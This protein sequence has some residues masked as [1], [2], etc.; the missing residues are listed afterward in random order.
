MSISYR[1]ACI[2]DLLNHT[3][4]SVTRF[5]V[6]LSPVF[7]HSESKRVPLRQGYSKRNLVPSASSHLLSGFCVLLGDLRKLSLS[8]AFYPGIRI[9]KRLV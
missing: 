7:L 5:S 4:E 1:Y 3:H 2:T 6:L 9:L 8:P